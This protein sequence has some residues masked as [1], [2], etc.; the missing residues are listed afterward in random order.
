MRYLLDYFE[1]CLE[2]KRTFGQDK[3]AAL[4]DISFLLHRGLIRPE[5]QTS[6]QTSFA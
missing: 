5:D 6:S 2:Q 4:H 3:D 1:G